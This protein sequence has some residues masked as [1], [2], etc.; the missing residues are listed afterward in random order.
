MQDECISVQAI[1]QL[2]TCIPRPSRAFDIALG[3]ALAR[4]L[5]CVEI[6][7]VYDAALEI[8][9]FK[10][11]SDKIRPDKSTPAGHK[12]VLHASPNPDKP[13]SGS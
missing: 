7:G 9:F 4:N 1:P 3:S 12:Y 10:E 5:I 13:A 11:V 8:G 6:S 2:A